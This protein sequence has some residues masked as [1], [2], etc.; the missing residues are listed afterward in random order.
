MGGGTGRGIGY[1]ALWFVYIPPGLMPP[2]PPMSGI[3]GNGILSPMLG[4]GGMGSDIIG[5]LLTGMILMRLSFM[6]PLN[7]FWSAIA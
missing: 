3:P 7:R 5:W 6:P 2:L 1:G 4:G